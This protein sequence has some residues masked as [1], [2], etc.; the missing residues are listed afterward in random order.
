MET[1]SSHC[2]R[3]TT[4][5]EFSGFFVGGASIT[6]RLRAPTFVSLRRTW[7]LSIHRLA[8]GQLTL[9]NIFEVC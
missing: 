5:A 9:L 4:V 6:V 1:Q 3:Q 8:V 7:Y 2:P